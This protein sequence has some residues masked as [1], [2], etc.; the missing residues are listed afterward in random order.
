MGKDPDFLGL[1]G[2]NSSASG[3][4]VDALVLYSLGMV[5]VATELPASA[6]GSMLLHAD[7]STSE[8]SGSDSDEQR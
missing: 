5:S 8:T 2:Y 7:A 6:D 1:N 4:R 3:V